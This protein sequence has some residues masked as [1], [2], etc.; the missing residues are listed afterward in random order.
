ME[1]QANVLHRPSM[2]RKALSNQEF[3]VDNFI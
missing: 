1:K 2:L 3:S